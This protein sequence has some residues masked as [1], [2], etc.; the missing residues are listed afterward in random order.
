MDKK[1]IKIGKRIISKETNYEGEIIKMT[2][3]YYILNWYF[4]PRTGIG[5]ENEKILREEVQINER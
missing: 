5:Y 2:E 4:N 3:K 1:Y